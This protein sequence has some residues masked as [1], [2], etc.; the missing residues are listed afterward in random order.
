MLYALFGTPTTEVLVAAGSNEVSFELTGVWGLL[1][2]VAFLYV[3]AVVSARLLGVRR[4]FWRAVIAGLA[5]LL[6]GEALVNAQFGAQEFNDP[7]DLTRLGLGFI[8]YV[9]LATMLTSVF[10]EVLLRPAQ[11]SGGWRPPH[12]VRAV[13]R[14]FA[15][16]GRLLE[17]VSAAR[18]NGLAGRRIPSRRSLATPEGAVALRRTLEDCGGMLVKF[19]QIASTRD[20]LLPA[21]VIGELAELRASVPAL[22]LEVVRTAILENLGDD[23]EGLLAGLSPTPLAAASIGVTHRATL[24]D[25]RRVIVKVQRPGIEEV[26][27]RDARVLRWAARLLERRSDSA[28]SLGIAALADELIAG[29]T[30]ELD[31]TREAANNAAIRRAH[32]NDPAVGYPLIYRELTTRHVLVMDEVVGGTVGDPALIAASGAPTDELAEA[33]LRAFLT[34]VLTDGVYHADPHPGNVLIDAAGR[35]WFID[36]GA[37]GHIDP[38]TLEALQQLALGFTTR[39]V[40][41]LAR[42][43][44][45]LA[46]SSG[47][48]FDMAAIEYE[49]GIV[50]TG[51]EGGGFDPA[52]LSAVVHVLANH[53]VR[54]PQALTVLGRAALTLEGTLRIIAPGFAMAASAQQQLSATFGGM[55]SNV[56]ELFTREAVRSLPSLRALP[57]LTEDLALQARA[58]RLTLRVDRYSGGDRP[59]LDRWV[60]RILFASLAAIGL[61]G[62]ALLLIAAGLAPNEPVAVVLRVI[63]FS[64]LV[65]ATAMQLRAIAQ[66]LRRDAATGPD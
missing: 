22:P 24:P 18:R 25:G 46:G 3:M 6:A 12:P 26:V 4:G 55:T 38:V 58:G 16:V 17:I 1:A 27:A 31:F 36:F 45:R 13:R 30:E 42:A 60:D 53:G 66:I 39:D 23:A 35:L 56:R 61:L 19:G 11:R 28:R 10:L 44:R 32:P 40:T 57:Q 21:T 9:L 43:L 2:L 52:A 54:A 7:S 64:G 47:E 20:D 49:L 37:V 59:V 15:V 33:L 48:Q 65:I 50:L 8:G 5:G 29:I 14:R 51:V 62:S 41:V 63:G 34:Q